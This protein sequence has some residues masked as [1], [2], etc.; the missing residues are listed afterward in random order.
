MKQ[1]SFRN[2]IAVYFILVTAILI[3]ILFSLIYLIVLDTVYTHLN[4]DL[5]A[6]AKEVYSSFVII[7]DNLI[8]ANPYEWVE[9][10]HNQ[11]EVNPTFIEIIDNNGKIIRKTSNL[12][13][14]K[15]WYDLTIKEERYFNTTLS[16]S[17]VRQLQKAVTN[18]KGKVLAYILIAIPLEESEL[19]LE[20]LKSTL[21]V[22]YP[23]VLII[24]FFISRLIAG[25]FIEPIDKVI[26]TA[27]RITRENLSER[28]EL[29][30]HQDEIYTLTLTINNLLERIE[31]TV[32]REKQFT[33]D[34]SHE[35]RTPLSIIKGTL[36]VLTRKPR[37]VN[38]YIEK[39]NLVVKE[40]DRMSLLIDQLLELAKFES[41]NIHPKLEKV[42]LIEIINNVYLRL[43]PFFEEKNSK[44]YFNISSSGI[45]SADSSMLNII[46]ENIISNSLKYSPPNK[47]IIVEVSQKDNTQICSVIDQGVGIPKEEISKIFDRFYRVDKSRTSRSSGLGL[48]I[49][50]R[51]ADI[52]NLKLSL[53]S[54]TNEGTIFTIT[55]PN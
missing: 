43:K 55:F 14:D 18:P 49:V 24:L 41:G 48:A 15:L 22:G 52:Q 10:E 12:K 33:A 30:S 26:K 21:L 31:D 42:D 38:Q 37:E 9:K 39:I 2:R 44:I 17:P 28:I 1:F 7:N 34:A 35:L 4:N 32:Q 6:E 20:N 47:P 5:D 46:F 50:K 11:I 45:V 40:I 54:N 53:Q 25:K 27:Q 19:V 36:E 3:A 23:I 13:D 8:F 16:G 51:L 29:P